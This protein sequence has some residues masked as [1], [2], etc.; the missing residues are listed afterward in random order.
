MPGSF[1]CL[2]NDIILK[3]ATCDLFE[4]TFNTLDVDPTQVKILDSFK[5]IISKQIKQKRG[6]KSRDLDKY[7]LEK[8]LKLT[9]NLAK[10]SEETFNNS[11]MKKKLYNQL[12]DYNP[13][14]NA[15]NNTIDEGEAVLISYVS[16]LN[17]QGGSHYL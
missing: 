7:N 13:E 15:Q 2:D 16:Y 11:S 10:L 3:L 4:D 1:Y 14:S 17:Q 5:Y 6:K 9:E 12:L 8:A